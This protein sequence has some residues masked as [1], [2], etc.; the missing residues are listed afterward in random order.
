VVEPADGDYD[1]ARRLWNAMIDGRP[2]V[3]ARCS[4]TADVVRAIAFAREHDLPIAVRG[5][6]H[7][8]AGRATVD[9]GLVIDL[10]PHARHPRRP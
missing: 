8:V 10:S 9:N 1:A 5:G 3:I 7:G 4:G 2:S 6:G